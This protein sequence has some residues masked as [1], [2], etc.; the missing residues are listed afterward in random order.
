[1][2]TEKRVG[3]QKLMTA[4]EDKHLIIENK[5]SRRKTA[6]EL[7]VELNSSQQQ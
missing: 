5:R 1:M 3:M 6:P 7:A 2:L 4:A